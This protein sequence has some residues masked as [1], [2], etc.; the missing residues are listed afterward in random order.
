MMAIAN[1]IP[2]PS[3]KRAVKEHVVRD[4]L[5]RRLRGQP[6]WQTPSGSIDVFTKDEVIEVKH[7]KG[8]KSGIGQVISYGSHYPSH[9][10]RLHLFAQKGEVA[11]KHFELAASVCSTYGIHVTF[12]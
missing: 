7:F 4:A 8:W 9:K 2:P 12:E 5:A 3:K 10:K 11:A 1:N 6:E